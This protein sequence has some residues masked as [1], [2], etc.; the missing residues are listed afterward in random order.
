MPAGVALAVPLHCLRGYSGVGDFGLPT[1]PVFNASHKV[2]I[3]M[4]C[5]WNALRHFVSLRI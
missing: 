2:S 3:V 1:A 5:E 4:Q